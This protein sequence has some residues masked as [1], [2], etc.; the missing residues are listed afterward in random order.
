MKA[1]IKSEQIFTITIESDLGVQDVHTG[2]VKEDTWNG[3]TAFR[4]P[5]GSK[6]IVKK[7]NA[8]PEVISRVFENDVVEKA[9][10]VMLSTS[11]IPTK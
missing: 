9:D 5:D 8:L 2:C 1:S 3:L 4:T 10:V 11:L 6:I 7:E